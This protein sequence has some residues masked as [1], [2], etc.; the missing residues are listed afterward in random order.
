[1][2]VSEQD[3]KAKESV[4]NSFLSKARIKVSFCYGYVALDLCD[5]KGN[6][7]S[8]L[9]AGLTRREA[10]FVLDAIA[11]LIAYEKRGK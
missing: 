11:K 9:L 10:L 3:L 8:A 1:M 5:N 4:L 2:R 7:V 6:I